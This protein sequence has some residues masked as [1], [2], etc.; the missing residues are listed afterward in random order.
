MKGDF[1]AI[2]TRGSAGAHFPPGAWDCARCVIDSL[3]LWRTSGKGRAS[4]ACKDDSYKRVFYRFQQPTPI[5]PFAHSPS[6]LA[7]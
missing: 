1:I 3:V 6:I 5:R 2:G 7:S 4:E